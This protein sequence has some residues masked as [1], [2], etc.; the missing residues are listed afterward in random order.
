[1]AV[2]CW[3]GSQRYQ[4][5]EDLRKG[6]LRRDSA[7]AAPTRPVSPRRQKSSKSASP[8]DEGQHQHDL[9]PC[10]AVKSWACWKKGWGA[11]SPDRRDQRGSVWRP[12]STKEAPDGQDTGVGT[13]TR[14][15][16]GAD[17]GSKRVGGANRG[18]SSSNCTTER[19]KEADAS[20]LLAVSPTSCPAVRTKVANSTTRAP[21]V[22]F[23]GLT[24][25]T[26]SSI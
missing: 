12:A 16:Q 5:Q 18:V 25:L 11:P 3:L 19:A 20:A 21:R 24:L 4:K 2:R 7:S 15:A 22:I 26:R 10:G 14:E 23:D 8:T 13:N 17:A 1:M 9:M 6:T